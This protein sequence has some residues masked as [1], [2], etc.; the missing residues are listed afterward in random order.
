M[1]TKISSD[2]AIR[3]QQLHTVEKELA[4]L[5]KNYSLPEF[6]KSAGVAEVFFTDKPL[7]NDAYADNI[8]KE[9]PCHT[10]AATWHSLVRFYE[11]A[12][13]LHPDVRERIHNRIKQSCDRWALNAERQKVEEQAKAYLTKIA[14][15]RPKV[16]TIKEDDYIFIDRATGV[17][18]LPVTD[19]QSVVK[20]AEWL[21]N[22]RKD[23]KFVKASEMA[24]RILEKAD[25]YSASLPDA[26]EFRLEKMAGYGM[27]NNKRISDFVRGK[28]SFAKTAEAVDMIHSLAKS[29][30]ANELF[31]SDTEELEKLAVT[32][33]SIDLNWGNPY[34]ADSIFP[35][36]VLF[37]T[38]V[39]HL[40]KTAEDLCQTTSGSIYKKSDFEKLSLDD[41][42]NIF[43]EDFA[44]EVDK[45]AMVDVEKMAELLP[46]SPRDD[47]EMFDRY[48]K[49]KGVKPAIKTAG[50]AI[51][52]TPEHIQKIAESS[53]KTGHNRPSVVPVDPTIAA[54]IGSYQS[55]PRR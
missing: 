22:H 7:P 44:E 8:N 20:V 9:F 24:K 36:D 35:E 49:Q 47:A 52:L 15:S 45:G 12:A 26:L 23:F 1:L 40:A 39:K 38:S 33:E 31:G 50:V 37:E 21:C 48:M 3:S 55:K 13:V 4:R 5:E 46:T 10:K 11:K 17:R 28:A 29:I 53:Q 25:Q 51:K 19:A 6:F 32:L 27:G 16:N 18:E 14:A 2:S 42:R 43:G 41:I 30:Q 34:K 54:P